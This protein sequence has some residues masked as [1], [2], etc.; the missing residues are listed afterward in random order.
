M[1]W[2]RRRRAIRIDPLVYHRGFAAGRDF[3]N[4]RVVL[5][6]RAAVGNAVRRPAVLRALLVLRARS[7]RP[8]GSATPTTGSRIVR[9]VRHQPRAL[10]CQSRQVQGLRADCWGLTAS[11]D[12]DG[13]SAHAPPDNDNGT[14]S[15]TAALSSLPYAPREVM[16]AL[17]H[18][19]T[20]HGERIWGRYGF[21]DAFCEQRNW[22][23]DTYPRHRPGSHHRHDG[24]SAHRPVVEA[25]HEHSGSADRACAGSDSRAPAWAR[26]TAADGGAGRSSQWLE[27][28]YRRAAAAMLASVSPVG[29]VKS[30]A[31]ASA[32]PSVPTEGLHRRL[33][34]A[35]GLR[36]GPGL[37][38]PLVPGFG[39]G[40]RCRAAAAGDG[41]LTAARRRSSIS[42]TSCASV[43][44]C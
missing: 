16:G 4:G 20:A 31:R 30:P 23:A 44:R 19:L 25:V 1:C 33:A 28:Q 24:E 12:P 37:F 5:R 42:A 41:G 38:L 40:D 10:R 11:D 35:G 7:P 9:H 8:E 21:V 15:P 2:R 43:S 39:G 32:R 22:Y 36:S 29:I 6:H 13:Y 3:L 17:R 26:R 27:Q 34:G 18:F 14:I